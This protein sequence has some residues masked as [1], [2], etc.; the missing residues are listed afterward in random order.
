MTPDLPCL[1]STSTIGGPLS[2]WCDEG[3]LDPGAT[4]RRFRIVRTEE[5]RE[6]GRLFDEDDLDAIVAGV[7][8]GA[9]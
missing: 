3:E 1:V 5:G 4:L 7:C 8:S 6:G 9:A 2:N